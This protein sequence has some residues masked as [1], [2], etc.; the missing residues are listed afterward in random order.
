[1]VEEVAKL[2]DYADR[3]K[4]YMGSFIA[5]VNFFVWGMAIA[6]YWLIALLLGLHR[7]QWTIAVALMFTFVAFIV[8][9]LARVTPTPVKAVHIPREGLRWVL[10]FSIPF[11]VIYSIPKPSVFYSVF[12]WYFALGIALLAVHFAVEREYVKK[13]LQIGTPFL[14]CGTAMLATSPLIVY[15]IIVK[16]Y[17]AWLLSLGLVLLTYCGTGIYCVNKAWKLFF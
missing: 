9:L 2:A 7:M 12:D 17:D 16:G 13:G 10:S 11:A 6:G 8:Y 1:M 4:K 5:A 14:F 3:L 15:A